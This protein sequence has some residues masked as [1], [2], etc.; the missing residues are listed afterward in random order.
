MSI[1]ICIEE[2]GRNR[3]VFSKAT[4]TGAVVWHTPDGSTWFVEDWTDDPSLGWM[5]SKPGSAPEKWHTEMEAIGYAY[6]IVRNAAQERLNPKE[7]V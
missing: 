1:E 3:H 4:R 5:A 6:Q 7:S 2:V